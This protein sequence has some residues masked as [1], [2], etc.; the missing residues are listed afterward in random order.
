MN[1]LTLQILNCAYVTP[2]RQMVFNQGKF[3]YKVFGNVFEASGDLIPEGLRHS[4]HGDHVYHSSDECLSQEDRESAQ[5]ICGK[6]LFAGHLMLHYGHFITEGLGR[7]YP[8]IKSIKFDRIAFFP[9]I[10]GVFSSFPDVLSDYHHFIFASLG[11]SLDQIILIRQSTCFDELW[12]P[13]PAWPINLTAHPV[14]SSIYHQ[15]RSFSFASYE[16]PQKI[17]SEKLYVARSKNL[18]SN[19]NELIEDVF[20]A[21]GFSVVKLEKYSFQEQISL[22]RQTKYLAGFS[23]SGLHN[24][25]FC[26]PTTSLIEITDSRGRQGKPLPMQVAANA[27]DSR[28][29]LVID[30]ETD[31]ELM[32]QSI[33]HFLN[34]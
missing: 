4:A 7:L 28:T 30:H 21:C 20:R 18:R 33:I 2:Y 16:F 17:V 10:F 32:K 19:H 14:M 23:G 1:S 25:I 27:I 34:R 26:P 24:I 31:L 12:V 22:L 5:V 11:I 13:S 8:L 3:K 6:V 9:F 29:S 15:I